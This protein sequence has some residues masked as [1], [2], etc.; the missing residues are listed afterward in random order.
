MALL[1]IAVYAILLNTTKGSVLDVGN[2]QQ[3]S[4]LRRNMQQQQL[5]RLR[6]NRQQQ[7]LSR[8]RRTMKQQQLNM[9]HLLKMILYQRLRRTMNHNQYRLFYLMKSSTC[10][11]SHLRKWL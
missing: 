8:L 10:N 11:L 2:M 7:Q 5:S 3:L 4:R 6:R 1:A 9:K